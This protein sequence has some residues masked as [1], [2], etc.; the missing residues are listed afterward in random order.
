MY[1]DDLHPHAVG[2][3]SV[4]RDV[5]DSMRKCEHGLQ[6]ASRALSMKCQ[7]PEI[8]E[9]LWEKIHFLPGNSIATDQVVIEGG[10]KI[11]EGTKSKGRKLLLEKPIRFLLLVDESDTWGH[12]V[13]S[14]SEVEG[15]FVLKSSAVLCGPVTSKLYELW[16]HKRSMVKVIYSLFQGLPQ[17]YMDVKVH[18]AEDQKILKMEI[19]PAGIRSADVTMQG[20]GGVIRRRT[21][22]SELPLHHWVWLQDDHSDVAIE[23]DGAFAFTMTEEMRTLQTGLVGFRTVSFVHWPQ[24]MP[25]SILTTKSVFILF[26]TFQRYFLNEACSIF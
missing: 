24:M 7:S 18:W 21:D 16:T 14:F 12:G 17:V 8:L 26:L 4:L 22:G 9:P 3:Y 2:C 23:Q 1:S 10:G 15:S 19:S 5:K 20:A 13:R 11:S 6:F 25:V